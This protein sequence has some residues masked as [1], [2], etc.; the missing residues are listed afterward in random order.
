MCITVLNFD[1]PCFTPHLQVVNEMPVKNSLKETTVCHSLSPT[2]DDPSVL[3][4]IRQSKNCRNCIV[5]RFH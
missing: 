4:F 1:A 3:F 5:F 2:T